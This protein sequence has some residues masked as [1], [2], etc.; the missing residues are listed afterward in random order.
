MKHSKIAF[1]VLITLISTYLQAL[2]LNTD[3]LKSE[4]H[5]PV[6]K[7]TLQEK[8]KCAVST[9]F[10]KFREHAPYF[11]PTLAIAGISTVLYLGTQ[12]TTKRGIQSSVLKFIAKPWPHLGIITTQL[13]W[14]Y[15]AAPI[16]IYFGGLPNWHP[17]MLANRWLY[18]LKLPAAQKNELLELSYKEFAEK[19]YGPICQEEW[20]NHYKKNE[21]YFH[22]L[23]VKQAA[24]E[25]I[26][27]I[28]QRIEEQL[29][30]S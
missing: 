28:N 29:K 21:K 7:L 24:I 15:L 4:L 1:L 19:I 11:K 27:E 20:E 5:L 6:P 14:D 26:T 17:S 16:L 12:F 8:L 22:M 13:A 30:N 2:P 9:S 3:E 10:D 23:L 18:S 25:Q